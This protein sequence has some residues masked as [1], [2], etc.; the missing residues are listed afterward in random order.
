MVNKPQRPID[1]NL[2]S[3]IIDT[4]GGQDSDNLFTVTYPATVTG[5]RWSLAGQSTDGMAQSNVYW[6]VVIVKDG[7]SAKS[8]A[9]SA[10]AAFYQPEQN[11]LAF[12]V[13]ALGP[14]NVSSFQL[15]EGHTKTMRKLAGG[16]K[17]QIIAVSQLGSATLKGVVQFF[18]KA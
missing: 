5:L 11:V 15:S 7:E 17:L 8:I 13:M 4:S 18:M 14:S 1:K 16:D 6:A 12:G 3:V 10:E 2:K 9:F